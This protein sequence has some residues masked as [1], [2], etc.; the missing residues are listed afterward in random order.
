MKSEWKIAVVGG[1]GG[2]LATF[3]I[4]F[5]AD[6]SGLLPHRSE[7]AAIHDYLMSHPQ[8][9]VDMVTKAQA[10]QDDADDK[11]RQQAVDKL[12]AKAFF[13]S[14]LAYVTGPAHAKSTVVEFFDYNCQYCRAS[15]PAMIKF[16]AKHKNDTRFAFIE[17]P[18]H[19][20]QSTLAAEAA[21]AARKQANKYVAF[22]F[23]LMSESD[24]VDANMIATDAQKAGL[25]LSK[26]Q[27][28][29][30]APDVAFA[31][32]AAH[33]LADVAKIDGTP[34]FIING[35]VR[36]GAVDDGILDQMVKG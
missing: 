29:M 2:A 31:I 3:A 13:N 19:G 18:F 22:H 17:F 12:G 8:I 9:A 5:A 23:A 35:K 30:K 20:P 4:L 33:R 15:I 10:E 27:N 34:A 16:Y 36:E 1:F 6:I 25:D 11:A 28:D 7:D 14:K 21:I 26:L 24:A 32:A